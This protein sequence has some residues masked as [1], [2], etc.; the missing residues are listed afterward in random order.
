MLVED[1]TSEARVRAAI[2]EEL[3]SLRQFEGASSVE[4]EGI[5][6]RIARSLRPILGS[7]NDTL[8]GNRA[9]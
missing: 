5:A 6:A 3:G 9:A 2:E 1:R 4:L 8:A 7:S